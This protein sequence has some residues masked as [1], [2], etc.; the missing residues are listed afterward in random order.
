MSGPAMSL[1]MTVDLADYTLENAFSSF[2]RGKKRLKGDALSQDNVS[3]VTLLKKK[4]GRLPLLLAPHGRLFAKETL[5]LCIV[6]LKQLAGH[7]FFFPCS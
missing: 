4:G 3:P 2:R 1:E 5:D 6:F 7:W